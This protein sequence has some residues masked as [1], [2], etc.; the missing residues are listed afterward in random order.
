MLKNWE[1]LEQGGQSKKKPALIRDA[2]FTRLKDLS[3][4]W[5]K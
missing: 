1:L 4:G 5:S 2:G 3:E